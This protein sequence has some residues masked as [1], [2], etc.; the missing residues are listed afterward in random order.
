MKSLETRHDTFQINTLMKMYVMYFFYIQKNTLQLVKNNRNRIIKRILP[1]TP[2]RSIEIDDILRI[3]LKIISIKT[4][5][6]SSEA[7][8][9]IDIQMDF[10]IKYKRKKKER[11][12]E[13]MKINCQSKTYDFSLIITCW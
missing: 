13:K 11:G 2:S 4:I 12:K 8:H 5:Y 6:D 3:F 1:K 10:G 7:K 9:I